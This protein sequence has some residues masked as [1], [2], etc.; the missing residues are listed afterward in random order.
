MLGNIQ[1][2]ES[3]LYKNSN[4]TKILHFHHRYVTVT[5]CYYFTYILN[6]LNTFLYKILLQEIAHIYVRQIHYKLYHMFTITYRLQK[7]CFL[8][9]RVVG[10]LDVINSSSCPNVKLYLILMLTKIFVLAGGFLVIHSGFISVLL[11]YLYI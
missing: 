3:C 4:W 9:S 5:Y 1:I 2:Y 8:G 10:V 7:A 11:Q 6:I